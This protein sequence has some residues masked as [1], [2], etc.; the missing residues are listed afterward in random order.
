M[1]IKVMEVI[2]S[3]DVLPFK[4]ID[5]PTQFSYSVAHAIEFY[6]SWPKGKNM[7]TAVSPAPI[8][9]GSVGDRYNGS[10]VCIDLPH[11][12]HNLSTHASVC[13]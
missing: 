13:M 11:M 10:S 5:L 3:F 12:C 7:N 6:S 1:E 8:Y 2:P 9:T 4:K